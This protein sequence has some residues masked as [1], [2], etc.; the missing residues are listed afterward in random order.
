MP[1][2]SS[3]VGNNIADYYARD[4]SPREVEEAEVD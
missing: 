3:L 1:A 2:H 4:M